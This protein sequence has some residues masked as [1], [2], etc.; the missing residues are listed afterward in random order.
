MA[1][2]ND[3]YNNA[4][5]PVQVNYNDAP[6]KTRVIIE[7][8]FGRWKRHFHVL[9][10]EVPMALEKVCIII[11][12]CVVLHN[13]AIL[14]SEPME[15]GDVSGEIDEHDV[16]CGPNQG[17]AVRNHITKTYFSWLPS[18]YQNLPQGTYNRCDRSSVQSVVFWLVSSML[19]KCLAA[20]H[21][22]FR[23]PFCFL[24]CLF[25]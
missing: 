1:I 19:H 22:L 25:V 18:F 4:S 15:D 9:H 16:Y 17:Q 3:P 12:A 5:T 14:L 7:Q 2:Y 10:F 23:Q 11:G 13:I 21:Y 20:T 8:T 6:C 24:A